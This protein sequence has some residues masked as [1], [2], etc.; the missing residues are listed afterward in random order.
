MNKE[1]LINYIDIEYEKSN[2][3]YL[4]AKLLEFKLNIMIGEFT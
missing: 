3:F 2:D 1:K 4:K